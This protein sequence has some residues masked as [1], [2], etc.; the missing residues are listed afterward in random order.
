M[1]YGMSACSVKLEMKNKFQNALYRHRF[2]Y[3]TLIVKSI[4]KEVQ[5]KMEKGKA[6]KMVWSMFDEYRFCW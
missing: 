1:N 2:A 5:H 3:G 4:P 6:T